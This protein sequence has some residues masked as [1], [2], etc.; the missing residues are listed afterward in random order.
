MNDHGGPPR[1]KGQGDD[2]RTTFLPRP[3]ALGPRPLYPAKVS[4]RIRTTAPWTDPRASIRAMAWFIRPSRTRW[5]SMTSGTWVSPSPGSFCWMASMLMPCSPRMLAMRGHDPGLVQGR[6][7]QVIGGLDLVHG[8]HRGVGQLV[9]LEGEVR[10]PVVGVRGQGPHHVHQVRHHRRGGRQGAG[11]G[12][13]VEGRTHRVALHQDRVHDA[14]DVGDEAPVG[15]QGR[16][17]PQLDP[18]RRS[19]GRCPGA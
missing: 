5:V 18:V 14:V 1:A 8:Q 9:R 6:Q 11:P 2:R 12:P 16:V 3:L 4:M 10:H 7:A 19:A 13:V 17:H 15:D